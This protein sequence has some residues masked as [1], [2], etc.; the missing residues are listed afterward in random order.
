MHYVWL[1]IDFKSIF[2]NKTYEKALFI[3]YIYNCLRAINFNWYISSFCLSVTSPPARKTSGLCRWVKNCGAS[4]NHAAILL[5]APFSLKRKRNL[6]TRWNFENFNYKEYGHYHCR[7]YVVRLGVIPLYS[8]IK[9]SSLFK[10][11][12]RDNQAAECQC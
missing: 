3:C 4:D 11:Q 8:Y 7:D 12:F 9:D 10:A 6:C 5:F 2:F 1:Q